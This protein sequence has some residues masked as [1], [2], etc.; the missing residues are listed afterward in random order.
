MPIDY[1]E[2]ESTRAEKEVERNMKVLS[3]LKSITLPDGSHV[4]V[5]Y[6]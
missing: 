6:E 2:D 3:D 4:K 5:V 1:N